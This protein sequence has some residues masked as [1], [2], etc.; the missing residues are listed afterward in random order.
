MDSVIRYGC[1]AAILA[2]EDAG[3]EPTESGDPDW[4]S[5][6]I[7]GSGNQCGMDFKT[8]E[9][10][11]ILQSKSIRRLGGSYSSKTLME[12]IPSRIA[13]YL[14]LGGSLCVNNTSATG[15]ATIEQ[16]V[17]YVESGYAERM[18]CG[19]AETPSRYVAIGLDAARVTVDSDDPKENRPLS[20]TA[21]GL[22]PAAGAGA[23]V[24]ESLE[25]AQQREAHIYAEVIGHHSNC[26]GQRGDG[27]TTSPGTKAICRCIEKAVDM[28]GGPEIDLI[29]GHL[30]GTIADPLEL[31]NWRATIGDGMYLHST[32]S[33]LGHTLCAC[34]AIETIACCL[35]MRD[36][37]IHPSINCEDLIPEAEGFKVPHETVE[38][39]V[40]T[41]AKGG[42]GFG[43]VNVIMILKKWR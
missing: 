16:G 6:V 31:E 37:F 26:G 38:T 9:L 24:V 33:L 17:K 2:W 25:S 11:D 8:E 20:Q 42:F 4:D 15:L 14:G 18:V 30:T 7:F 3:L 13:A 12:G 23:V 35:M 28:A 27:T 32:K 5:G 10:P 22:V 21:K 41:V 1:L 29:N 34:G 36:S 39:E 19:G 40:R 43:D